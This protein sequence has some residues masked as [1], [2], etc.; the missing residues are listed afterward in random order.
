MTLTSQQR[1][2]LAAVLV[3][4][5]PDWLHSGIIDATRQLAERKAHWG[6]LQKQAIAAAEVASNRDPVAILRVIPGAQSATKTTPVRPCPVHSGTTRRGPD[7]PH[8]CC[9][10]ELDPCEDC[11]PLLAANVSTR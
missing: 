10:G 6:V 11:A 5:R 7:G 9:I 4:N 3:A 8:V 2:A 1:I